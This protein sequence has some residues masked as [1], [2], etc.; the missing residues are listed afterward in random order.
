MK[1]KK[2]LPAILEDAFDL[3][4]WNEEMLDEDGTEQEFSDEDRQAL[5]KLAEEHAVEFAQKAEGYGKALQ[6]IEEENTV[7]DARIDALEA[8]MQRL[9]ARRKTRD[10]NVN[11]M[12]SLL[13]RAMKITKMTKIKTPLFSFSIRTTKSIDA[14]GADPFELPPAF[15]RTKTEVNKTAINDAIKADSLVELADG[16]LVYKGMVLNGVKRVEKE[17]LQIR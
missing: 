16:T 9:K 7:I 13:L 3:Q 15:T 2:T 4:I 1:M 12:K 10:N 17:S 14:D 5:I 8:E 11:F 6:A